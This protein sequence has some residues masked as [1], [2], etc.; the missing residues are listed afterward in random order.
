MYTHELCENVWSYLGLLKQS[1]WE[2]MWYDI[3][4][5]ETNQLAVGLIVDLSPKNIS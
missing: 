5:D 4:H 2:T 3:S 1:L